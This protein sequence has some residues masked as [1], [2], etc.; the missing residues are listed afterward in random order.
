MPCWRNRCR[1]LPCPTVPNPYSEGMWDKPSAPPSS[2]VAIPN[3]QESLP[4]RLVASMD[5]YASPW[6]ENPGSP[7]QPL[8]EGSQRLGMG[9]R[10]QA[11]WLPA[12]CPPRRQSGQGI[13]S[14]GAMTGPQSIPGLS[15]RF[16]PS[17]SAQS[18]WTGNRFGLVRMASRTST[19]CTRMASTTTSSCMPSTFSN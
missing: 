13:H 15:T 4:I 5:R 14:D 10:N 6:S 19:S 7:P 11:R 16:C 17:G 18:S 3:R 9:P 2:R 1:L 8:P 12:D